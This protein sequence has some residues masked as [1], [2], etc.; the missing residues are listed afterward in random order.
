MSD[1]HVK[2]AHASTE[3]TLHEVRKRFWPLKGRRVIRR[4]IRQCGFC[5]KASVRPAAPFMA[6]LPL[7]GITPG[8]PVFTNCGVDYFGPFEVIVFRRRVKRWACM[9]TCL[10]SRAMHLEMA[11]SLDT[12]SFLAAMFRFEQRRGTPAA[13][14]SDNGKNFVGADRELSIL[15]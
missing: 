5:K 10:A 6:S 14:W 8:L 9:F 1:V 4:V 13:Y 7:A 15:L 3:G 2:I 12:D 11:Y